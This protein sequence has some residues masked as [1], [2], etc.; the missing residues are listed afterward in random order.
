M[1][2]KINIANKNI[3]FCS[4]VQHA[5]P[6]ANNCEDNDAFTREYI[7]NN[8]EENLGIAYKYADTMWRSL[9]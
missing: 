3:S 4:S 5:N 2:Q 8:I 6:I 7:R 9:C 1:I